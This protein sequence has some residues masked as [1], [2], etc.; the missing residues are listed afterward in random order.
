MLLSV[1]EIK[2]EDGKHEKKFMFCG[3]DSKDLRDRIDKAKQLSSYIK[4]IQEDQ[5]VY[6]REMIYT[7]SLDEEHGSIKAEELLFNNSIIHCD[8]LIDILVLDIDER[9]DMLS[10]RM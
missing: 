6:V 5:E 4:T 8:T 3:D 10:Q 2:S 9:M 7:L 1:I